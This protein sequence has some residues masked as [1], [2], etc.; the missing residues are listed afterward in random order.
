MTMSDCF[1]LDTNTIISALLLPT[2]IPRQAFDHA[3]DLGRVIV[4]EATVAELADV[5]QRSRFD[6]YVREDARL[7]FLATF[8][9]DA[10]LI[11]VTETITD[12]RDPKDN[13]FLEVAVS[14][15]ATVIITGDRD[16]LD[17]HPYRGIAIITPRDFIN[18]P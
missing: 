3:F 7:Q 13:K 9:R 12:C 4:S 18:R 2:S 16:L 8:T 15:Q 10:M 11:A 17:L 5:L 1:V 14:G 6:E